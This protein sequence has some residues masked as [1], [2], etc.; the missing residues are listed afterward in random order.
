M[1]QNYLSYQFI[2][3]PNTVDTYDELPLWSALFGNLLLGNIEYATGL[4]ILD[5][6]SGTGF[7]LLEIASR[8]GSSCA[9]Y[10]IDTWTN[11][12]ERA[13]KKCRNYG[14]KNVTIIDGSANALPFAEGSLD[15]IVSNLGINNFADRDKVFAECYRVLKPEGKLALTTNLNGHWQLFYEVFI[16]T[17]TEL[18][19]RQIVPAVKEH[20]ELRGTAESVAA[21]F[22][23]AGF[24]SMRTVK[25]EFAMKFASGSA[26]LNHHFV[27]LGWLSGWIALIPDEQTTLF[28]YH[29]EANLKKASHG[30]G[31]NL[32][33][34]ALFMEGVKPSVQQ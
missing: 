13:R 8:F 18:N 24:G 33:V 15:L 4:K 29:L 27:K 3:N 21:L 2:D 30:N 26:F 32:I 25:S 16:E 11:A 6:G 5:I 12:N 19:L 17:L 28:F 10:G 20:C 1:A 34:P 9:C 31:L 14:L 22:T 7:P 23:N